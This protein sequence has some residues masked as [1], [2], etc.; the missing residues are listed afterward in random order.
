ME[1]TEKIHLRSA[2]FRDILGTPPRW[3]EQYGITLAVFGFFV[4]GLFSYYF[5]YPDIIKAP[6]KISTA[7]PP[8]SILPPSYGYLEN[9]VEEH[10]IVTKEI[11]WQYCIRTMLNLKIFLN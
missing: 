4:V 9:V 2:A 3:I 5:T 1:E 8:Q 11:C 10:S 7:E 6:I